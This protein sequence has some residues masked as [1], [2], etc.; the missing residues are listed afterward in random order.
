M[1]RRLSVFDLKDDGLIHIEGETYELGSLQVGG[2]M[3]DI[4]HIVKAEA[5]PDFCYGVRNMA[6][7]KA[8]VKGEEML[9]VSERHFVVPCYHCEVW[10]YWSRP[11]SGGF[12]LSMS[13]FRRRFMR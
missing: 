4:D 9:L 11:K 3:I 10:S 2:M 12:D 13:W 7:C 6:C 8:A 5:D 1:N